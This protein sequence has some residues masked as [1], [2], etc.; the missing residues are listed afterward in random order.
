MYSEY[1][2]IVKLKLKKK[3]NKRYVARNPVLFTLQC[4]KVADQTAGNLI[5]ST[6]ELWYCKFEHFREGF[7][8]RNFEVS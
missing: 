3:L 4:D 8:S 2:F 6:Y 1:I 5:Y 7:F